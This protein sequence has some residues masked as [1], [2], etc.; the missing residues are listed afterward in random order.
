MIQVSE[1][2]I[3]QIAHMSLIRGKI[4]EVHTLECPVCNRR[5]HYNDR[6]PTPPI[7]H[8][9]ECAWMEARVLNTPARILQ[10]NLCM[11]IV[12][13]TCS[14]MSH[15]CILGADIVMGVSLDVIRLGGGWKSIKCVVVYGNGRR[16]CVSIWANR[17][18]KFNDSLREAAERHAQDIARAWKTEYIGIAKFNAEDA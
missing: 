6:D 17:S 11:E 10:S 7:N 1:S 12:L 2:F 3:R 16:R 13:P 8:I 9:K 5:V 15:E 18:R 4:G 14:D